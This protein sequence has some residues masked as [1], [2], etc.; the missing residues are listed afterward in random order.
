[1]LELLYMSRNYVTL[2][3]LSRAPHHVGWPGVLPPCSYPRSGV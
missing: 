2:H 3:A 1:M